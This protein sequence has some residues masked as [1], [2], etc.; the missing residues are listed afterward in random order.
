MIRQRYRGFRALS[1]AV[2][3][4]VLDI[5]RR[6][7]ALPAQRRQSYAGASTT[8]RKISAAVLNVAFSIAIPKP[9]N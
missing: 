7:C 8:C 5:Y 4:R 3:T 9:A 6:Y 1:P 2:R